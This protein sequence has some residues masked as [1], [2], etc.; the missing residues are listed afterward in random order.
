LA[1]IFD[2]V[3]AVEADARLAAAAS[4]N[5]ARNS[6]TNVRQVADTAEAFAAEIT[7]A[8]LRQFAFAVVDP[9]RTGLTSD[10][11]EIM[12]LI[13]EMIVL[14]CSQQRLAE[15]LA[16]L[17]QTHEIQCCC[18]MDHFPYSEQSECGVH[19]SS[20]SQKLNPRKEY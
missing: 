19:L 8:G 13:P 4:V 17:I 12:K 20:R 9:P 5:Y 15:S 3:V 10:V 2:S 14:S 7:D 1:G 6:V 18:F 11:I 16:V